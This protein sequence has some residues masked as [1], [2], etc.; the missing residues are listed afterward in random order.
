MKLIIPFERGLRPGQVSAMYKIYIYNPIILSKSYG[1]SK[2]FSFLK[3]TSLV[4][5]KTYN[6]YEKEKDLHLLLKHIGNGPQIPEF[7]QVLV[8][9]PKR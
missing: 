5:F 8:L 7:K 9:V 1:I 4:E 2:L 3:M 6:I